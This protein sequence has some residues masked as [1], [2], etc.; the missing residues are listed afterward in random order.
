MLPSYYNGD[1]AAPAEANVYE[2][3]LNATE[4][5]NFFSIEDLALGT[6]KIYANMVVGIEQAARTELNA[7]IIRGDMLY[8]T[9]QVESLQMFNVNGVNVLE[10]HAAGRTVSVSRLPR[11]LYVAVLKGANGSIRNIYCLLF[12]RQ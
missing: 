4:G 2:V 12:L 10:S 1:I 7:Y 11:G 9:P 5:K 6:L 8:I 3:T